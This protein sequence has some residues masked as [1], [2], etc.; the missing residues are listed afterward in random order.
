MLTMAYSQIMDSEMIADQAIK[1]SHFVV[2]ADIIRIGLPREE[3]KDLTLGGHTLLLHT[4]MILPEY[5][6]TIL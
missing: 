5:I 6:T 2:S 3:I 1:S 4:K